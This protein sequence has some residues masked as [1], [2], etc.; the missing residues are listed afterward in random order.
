[1]V[2]ER[3]A[4]GLGRGKWGKMVTVFDFKG[5]ET[6]FPTQLSAEKYLGCASGLVTKRL[7]MKYKS[8]ATFF[9]V[10]IKGHPIAPTDDLDEC[11]RVRELVKMYKKSF[12][13]DNKDDASIRAVNE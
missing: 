10:M 3:T 1:M 12:G 9:I 7:K 6:I 2:K 4:T 5:N 11:N 13:N 8:K